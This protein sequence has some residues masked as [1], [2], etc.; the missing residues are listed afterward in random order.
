MPSMRN[1]LIETIIEHIQN[2]TEVFSIREALQWAYPEV[3]QGDGFVSDAMDVWS[4]V[5][6]AVQTKMDKSLIPITQFFFEDADTENMRD[7]QK[8]VAGAFAR[9]GPAVGAKVAT[10]DLVTKAWIDHRL[11]SAKGQAATTLTDAQRLC[12]KLGLESPLAILRNEFHKLSLP[13]IDSENAA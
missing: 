1:E 13:D 2:G 10:D 9:T 7:A 4:G 3:P 6:D 8:C 11:S 12:A 5:I